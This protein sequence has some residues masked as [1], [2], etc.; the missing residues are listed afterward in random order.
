MMM[1]LQTQGMIS[2]CFSLH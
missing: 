2:R 1:V